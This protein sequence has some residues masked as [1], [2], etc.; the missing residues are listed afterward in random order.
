VPAYRQDLARS[1]TNLGLLLQNTGRLKEAEGEYRRALDLFQQLARDFPA[2][3]EYRQELAASH[4]SLGLLLQNTGRLQEAE[5]E[6]RRALDL[7]QQLADDFPAVPAYRQELAVSHNSLGVLLADTGRGQEAEGE[8]R[9]ALGLQ[10]QLA[11]D[12]PAVPDYHNGLAG[13][14]VNLALLAQRRQDWA[15][16]RRLLEEAVPY[17]QAALKANPRHPLYRTFFRNNTRT[18]AETLLHLGDHAAAA[19]AADRLAQFAVNPPNDLYNPAC[20][21]S[22]C[23]PLAAKDDK[24]PEAKRQELAKDY[25]DR[26]MTALR[27]AVARGYK[28]AAHLKKDP[29]L[30]PLRRRDDFQKLLAGLEKTTAP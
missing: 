10:Q 26:A 29:D 22:R 6:Y 1:H 9:Q 24:L 14:L 17:H 25:A 4:N 2:V 27:Q 5:G 23:V 30:D 7:F 13:T 19:A 16:A 18:L 3:P 15:G 12:F 20:F 8:Y 11:H 21:L 28:D